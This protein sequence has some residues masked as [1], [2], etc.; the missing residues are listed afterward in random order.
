MR[1][2]YTPF[3][4]SELLAIKLVDVL[5]RKGAS[6]DTYDEM[7][8]W[9]ISNLPADANPPRFIPRQTLLQKLACRHNFPTKSGQS[10][11]KG[12]QEIE[13]VKESELVLP[14]TGTLVNVVHHDARD[15]LTSLLTDPRFGDDDYLHFGDNPLAPPPAELDYLGDV[16]TGLSYRETHDS[17]D[18]SWHN[19]V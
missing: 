16:N 2:T 15:M 14:H 10:G 1:D 13:F 6:L 4:K 9:H 19:F 8:A 5:K 18:A 7:M 11:A 12:R 17:L 3:N